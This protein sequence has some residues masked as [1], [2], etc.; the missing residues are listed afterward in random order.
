MFEHILVPLDGS[1]LAEAA[2][3]AAVLL[4]GK[5]RA[6]LTLIH[7][8][9]KNA[10]QEVHGQPHLR[11]AAAAAEYLTSLARRCV[12]AEISVDF[13]V[14]TAEVRDVADSIVAHADELHHD[15]IVMCAHGRGR[16]L[17]LF[18]G[19]IAQTVIGRGSLPV[20]IVRPDAGGSTAPFACSSILTPLDGN[21]EHDERSLPMAR[22]VA[23]A[24][25]AALHLA[26]VIPEFDN[27]SGPLTVTSR[28]LPGTTT[29][30]LELSA[31]DAESYLAEQMDSLRRDGVD[32]Q[33]QVR[34]GDPAT[35]I[36][37]VALQLHADVIVLATHG[38]SGMEALW[39]G[40]VAHKVCSRCNLPLLLA[41]IGGRR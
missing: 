31:R 34:R 1:E 14:H 5:F 22:D 3:P 26:M 7:V 28:L 36:T 27:L 9:E 30:M 6:A 21:P 40:S 8:I 17:R 38:K 4:A 24:C 13:H 35:A 16:A 10:P 25:G 33:A 39:A 2:L 12:P 15:L 41:P 32:G 37:D 23:R 18:L 19:S 20:L 29:K 11:D